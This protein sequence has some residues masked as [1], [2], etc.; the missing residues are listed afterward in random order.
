MKGKLIQ[1]PGDNT[2]RGGWWVNPTYVTSVQPWPADGEIQCTV[3]V[4]GEYDCIRSTEPPSV[5]AKYINEALSD[6]INENNH[7]R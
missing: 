5:V 7:S 2:K 6:R 1:I 3:E 4:H